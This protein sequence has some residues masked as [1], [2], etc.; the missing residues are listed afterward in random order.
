MGMYDSLS[1]NCPK[2]KKGLQL[3]SKSG[4]CMLDVF[5]KEDLPVHVALGLDRDVVECQFCKTNWRFELD[6]IPEVAK[7]TLMKTKEKAHYP[8]NYNPDS[9]EN[10]LRMTELRKQAGLHK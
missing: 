9:P 5:T 8:G 4:A 10:M 1:V 2:C 3:Q 6:S 7:F